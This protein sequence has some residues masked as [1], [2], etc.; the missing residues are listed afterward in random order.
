MPVAPAI[1]PPKA[2][3]APAKPLSPVLPGEPVPH[4]EPRQDPLRPGPGIAPE[5]KD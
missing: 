1:E 5:P 2:P 3:P 4:P